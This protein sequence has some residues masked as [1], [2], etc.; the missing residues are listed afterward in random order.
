MKNSI[1]S[2]INGH[3]MVKFGNG[4]AQYNTILHAK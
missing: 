4:V 1:N 3:I 2:I